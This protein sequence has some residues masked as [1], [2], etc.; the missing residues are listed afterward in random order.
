[1][2]P[3][4]SRRRDSLSKLVP[5]NLAFQGLPAFTFSNRSQ[6]T[7]SSNHRMGP[8]QESGNIQHPKSTPRQFTNRDINSTASSIRRYSP[9]QTELNNTSLCSFPKTAQANDTQASTLFAPPSPH[10]DTVISLQNSCNNCLFTSMQQASYHATINNPFISNFQL[11]TGDK[12][13]STSGSELSD[14][15]SYA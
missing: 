14:M 2:H 12:F 6:S 5:G 7:A 13:L 10:N 11:M 8:T 3:V 1:M 9:I 15:F 4:I